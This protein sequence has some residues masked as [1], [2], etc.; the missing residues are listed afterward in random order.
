M[1]NP[2]PRFPARNAEGDGADSSTMICMQF[3]IEGVNPCRKGA[4]C[5]FAHLNAATAVHDSVK[6]AGL[7]KFL[8]RNDVKGIL[9]P[10]PAGQ[11]FLGGVN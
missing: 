9:I 10:T 2:K 5:K 4:A 3:T 6:Y 1:V 11:R 7:T 8:A